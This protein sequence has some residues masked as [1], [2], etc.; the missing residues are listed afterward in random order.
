MKRRF[1]FLLAAFLLVWPCGSRA[2]VRM[3]ED[4]P[5]LTH[6]ALLAP[7]AQT[8]YAGYTLYQPTDTETAE[9]AVLNTS[10]IDYPFFPVVAVKEDQAVLIL[11]RRE[12]P[13][14][15]R[16]RWAI[17]GIYEKALHHPSFTLFRFSMTT[18]YSP[19][20]SSSLPVY[21]HYMRG[22]QDSLTLS[23]SL[24]AS[25]EIR[26]TGLD[27]RPQ[28]DVTPPHAVVFRVLFKEDRYLFR[29]GSLDHLQSFFPVFSASAQAPGDP[30]VFDLSAV[31]FS[32]CDALT[33]CLVRAAPQDPGA[34]I[35][36]RQFPG[37]QAA[38][39]RVLAPGDA[40]RYD[41]A[42]SRDGWVLACV[43]GVLGYLPIG[44]IAAGE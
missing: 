29:Y 44:N 35:L 40:A 21:F 17:H 31:P 28:S 15:S 3:R 20:P 22:E 37:A 8:P 16:D 9:D 1:F 26:F 10:F 41:P 14:D 4:Q 36:L 5:L 6:Q 2:L 19:D 27:Y 38:V 18:L 42:F 7:I 34:P 39:L 23:L 25:G 30:D 11:L 32:P 13:G 43:E 33:P 12:N 24:P